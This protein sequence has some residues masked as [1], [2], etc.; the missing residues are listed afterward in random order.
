VC[1]TSWIFG[2]V[3]QPDATG[4]NV[5]DQR[6]GREPH[7]EDPPQQDHAAEQ[8]ERGDHADDLEDVETDPHVRWLLQLQAVMIDE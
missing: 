5:A 7:S 4:Q 1:R 2:E 6:T 8:E 3:R